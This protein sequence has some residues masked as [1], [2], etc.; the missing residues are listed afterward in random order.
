VDVVGTR[1][2]GGA[3][4]CRSPNPDDGSS[5]LVALMRMRQVGWT[6]AAIHTRRRT[7]GEGSQLC[8]IARWAGIVV[9]GPCRAA[10]VVAVVGME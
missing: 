2:Q 4:R 10:S 6:C 1:R 3:A 8:A 9:S 5:A 7:G